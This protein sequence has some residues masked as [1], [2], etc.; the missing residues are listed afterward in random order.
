GQDGAR[1]IATVAG[2]GYTFVAS[3][4]AAAPLPAAKRTAAS[5]TR[6]GRMIGREHDLSAVREILAAH[7]FVTIHGPGGIGKTTLG[8][9]V[10]SSKAGDVAD[11]VCFVDLSLNA[12]GYTVADAVAAAL[13]LVV[14]A[15]DP[16]ANILNFIRDRDMLLVLD[17][18]EATIDEAAALAES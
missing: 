12:G 5:T 17:S 9:A 18:C 6:S 16:T 2:R 10:A 3:V 4:T 14:R 13:G 15:S 11:D 7:Q 1:Y 8:L